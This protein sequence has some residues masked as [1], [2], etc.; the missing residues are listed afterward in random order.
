MFDSGNA[1]FLS[2]TC[3]SNAAKPRQP[4][5]PSAMTG[6]RERQITMAAASNYNGAFFAS[7]FERMGKREEPIHRT[8]RIPLPSPCSHDAITANRPSAQ[9]P[10]RKTHRGPSPDATISLEASRWPVDRSHVRLAS[11]R[12]RWDDAGHGPPALVSTALVDVGGDVGGCGG[13]GSDT[14]LI[15]PVRTSDFELVRL[16]MRR[17]WLPFF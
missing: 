6:S 17:P 16:A 13:A 9:T 11:T 3:I 5:A 7:G 2:L 8:G 14:V 12:R 10:M 15:V 4:I 1:R